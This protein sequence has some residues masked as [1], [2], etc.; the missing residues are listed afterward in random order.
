MQRYQERL[1]AYQILLAG[2]QLNVPRLFAA[3]VLTFTFV[4]AMVALV[5]RGRI[6]EKESP[7]VA[8]IR[9]Q[10]KDQQARPH[11]ANA[12]TR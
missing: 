10:M 9:R 4:P 6:A 12:T 11:I 2:I 3:L 8:F 1:A 7:V 5:L